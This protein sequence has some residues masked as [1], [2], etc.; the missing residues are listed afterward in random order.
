MSFV[1]HPDCPC[2]ERPIT[3]RCH[4]SPE[5]AP[6]R[7]GGTWLLS[8]ITGWTAVSRLLWIVGGVLATWLSARTAILARGA[9]GGVGVVLAGWTLAPAGGMLLAVDLAPMLW[10][11]RGGPSSGTVEQARLGDQPEDQ[12]AL[13][14]QPRDGERDVAPDAQI[15]IAVE[16]ASFAAMRARLR[17]DP[18]DGSGPAVEYDCEHGRPPSRRLHC[19]GRLPLQPGRTYRAI[20]HG[21]LTTEQGWAPVELSWA[22]TTA[23]SGAVRGVVPGK[24]T[25]TVRPE[26]DIVLEGA[27]GAVPQHAAGRGWTALVH[28]DDTH[29]W[30]ISIGPDGSLGGVL[31][32]SGGRRLEDTRDFYLE[33]LDANGDNVVRLL[34]DPITADQGRTVR[35]IPGRPVRW[36]TPDGVVVVFDGTMPGGKLAWITVETAEPG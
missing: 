17:L 2:S 15:T 33:L 8:Q 32:T 27:A 7:A 16:G 19:S 14:H 5:Q 35:L 13:S 4:R 34:L 9:G 10:T 31:P 20:F 22:F 21:W 6:G 36:T 28:G 25:L 26:Q 30:P 29:Q 12:A 23:A 24:I 11:G 18:D 1:T 3:L